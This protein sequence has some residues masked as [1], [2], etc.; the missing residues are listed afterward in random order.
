MEPEQKRKYD[1]TI[2]FVLAW[3]AFGISVLIVLN[4]A[5]SIGG[6]GSLADII[7]RIIGAIWQSLLSML[8][9][10]FFMLVHIAKRK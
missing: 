2:A 4:A 10:I 7:G 6:A 9:A 8:A 3:I 1:I 5:A